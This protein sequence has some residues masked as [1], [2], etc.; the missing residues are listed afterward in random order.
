VF[1]CSKTLFT[2]DAKMNIRFERSADSRIKLLDYFYW[3]NQESMDL[4]FRVRGT[5]DAYDV[6]WHR[7]GKKP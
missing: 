1:I 6:T 5:T 4:Q 2:L 7:D 3:G